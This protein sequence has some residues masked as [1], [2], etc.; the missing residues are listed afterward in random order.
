MNFRSKTAE[1]EG[2]FNKV[3]N[4]FEKC[5]DFPV[6]DLSAMVYVFNQP[7]FQEFYEKRL[8][9]SDNK[10]WDVELVSLTAFM[11]AVEGKSNE[12][13]DYIKDNT[14][15]ALDYSEF[16][17]RDPEVIGE[18]SDNSVRSIVTMIHKKVISNKLRATKNEILQL[19]KGIR[20]AASAMAV[21]EAAWID[22]YIE[23]IATD[24]EIKQLFQGYSVNENPKDLILQIKKNINDNVKALGGNKPFTATGAFKATASA[25][26][27]D[28]VMRKPD[29]SLFF[30]YANYFVDTR[31]ETDQATRHTAVLLEAERRF[32]L[33]NE[34][35]FYKHYA[36]TK[37]DYKD[38]NAEVELW[39][40]ILA[41]KEE[42]SKTAIT[43]ASYQHI[44][45]GGLL[46]SMLANETCFK[47][48]TKGDAETIRGIVSLLPILAQDLNNVRIPSDQTI[49]EISGSKE[50]PFLQSSTLQAPE[51]T[52]T[53]KTNESAK[54]DLIKI[55]KRLVNA[56]SKIKN[57]ITDPQKKT[58][59][60]QGQKTTEEKIYVLPNR[61]IQKASTASSEEYVV[62]LDN[63]PLSALIINIL[64]KKA[65]YRQSLLEG[66]FQL[67]ESGSMKEIDPDMLVFP[68]TKEEMS[69]FL[70]S[71]DPS[72]RSAL[73]NAHIKLTVE[74]SD[75][76]L[77]H[78]KFA[79]LT[80]S[81]R[82][83]RLDVLKNYNDTLEDTKLDLQ[84]NIPALTNKIDGFNPAG[85]HTPQDII[86]II[87]SHIN[88]EEEGLSTRIHTILRKAKKIIEL[89]S[90]IEEAK[91]LLNLTEPSENQLPNPTSTTKPTQ[92]S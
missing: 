36:A 87:K 33:N 54:F 77:T 7:N 44:D 9:D 21:E 55:I 90:Q 3:I 14:S 39:Q 24:E 83:E 42:Y 73:T 63:E 46:N 64:S 66:I 40:S 18:S 8:G 78:T 58:N 43:V 76:R 51:N 84:D 74:K 31:M 81:Q 19:S 35:S 32:Q 56:G 57:L 59:Q 82:V 4:D 71:V 11:E 16:L 89:E 29:D 88:L 70:Q 53:K 45:N 62:N 67:Y 65:D 34:I 49:T 37:K 91:V 26:R 28:V 38:S 10:T 6:S 50:Y 68:Q 1:Y 41:K 72:M 15:P 12:I 79:T 92:G 75:N 25:G 61:T 2:S 48:L 20:Q 13:V 85:N 47:N 27:P 52:D 80:D 22:G 86:N 30:S 69:D 23:E 17:N 60:A 5:D